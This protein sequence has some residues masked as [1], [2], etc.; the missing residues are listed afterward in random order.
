MIR[1]FCDVCGSEFAGEEVRYSLDL[2]PD[3]DLGEEGHD[4]TIDGPSEH[5]PIRM[6]DVCLECVAVFKELMENRRPK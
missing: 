3:F 5:E 1:T 4:S 6:N 2:I